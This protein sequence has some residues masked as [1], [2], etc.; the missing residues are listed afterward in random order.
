MRIS[1]CALIVILVGALSSCSGPASEKSPGGTVST[2]PDGRP[3]ILLILA[4]D[5]GYGDVNFRLSGTTGFNN[6]CIKT[7]NLAELAAESLILTHHYSASPVCS[8]A[9]A[10]LPGMK[11]ERF[12]SAN[13][14]HLATEAKI[15][16]M[17]PPE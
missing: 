1:L 12:A 7:P 10:G 13:A 9:R 11:S 14:D 8:P 5:L 17:Y 16:A 4:D 3:K 2:F 6:P 15:K